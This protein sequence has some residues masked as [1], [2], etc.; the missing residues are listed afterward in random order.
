MKLDIL[1]KALHLLQAL[2]CLRFATLYEIFF[3]RQDSETFSF[4][5]FMGYRD[6]KCLSDIFQTGI[7]V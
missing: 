1:Y 7:N 6:N 2:Y 4:M 3:S 5:V